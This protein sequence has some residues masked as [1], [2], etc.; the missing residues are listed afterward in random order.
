VIDCSAVLELDAIRRTFPGDSQ[1]I[2]TPQIG[3][4]AP[5]GSE[6]A[7]E[8]GNEGWEDKGKV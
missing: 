7:K 8:M 4:S 6:R 1:G 2:A 5:I 3:Q